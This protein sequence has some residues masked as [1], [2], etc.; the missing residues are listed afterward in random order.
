[1]KG[2]QYNLLDDANSKVD[3][4]KQIMTNNVK[5]VVREG[6]NMD[7]LDE[8]L[9]ASKQVNLNAMNVNKNAKKLK[10]ETDTCCCC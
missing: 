2:N 7:Q 5:Q 9:A 8:Q 3:E 6:G 4:T 10:E 1:M